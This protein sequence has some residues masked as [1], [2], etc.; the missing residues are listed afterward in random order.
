M[1]D[2]H[3][4]LKVVNSNKKYP[5]IHKKHQQQ[6]Q[7]TKLVVYKKQNVKLIMKIVIEV[8][9]IECKMT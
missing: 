1:Y 5:T 2:L 9:K 6:I 3:S 8:K 7:T 4:E